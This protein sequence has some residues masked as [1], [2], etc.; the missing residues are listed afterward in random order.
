MHPKDEQISKTTSY[1]NSL[2]WL[3]NNIEYL[4]EALDKSCSDS[5]YLLYF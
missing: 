3:L 4:S 1:F 5:F 2:K